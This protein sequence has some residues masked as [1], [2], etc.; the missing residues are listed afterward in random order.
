MQV[1]FDKT[2]EKEFEKIY[3]KFKSIELKADESYNKD[4][5]YL[6]KRLQVFE[7][8]PSICKKDNFNSVAIDGS[9]AE[10]IISLNDISVH[11]LTAAFAADRTHFEEGTTKHLNISPPVCT[12][13]E[14][15]TRLILL[16]EDKKDEVWQEFLDF[17]LYNYNEKL[18]DV[19]IRVIRDIVEIAFKQKKPNDPLPK[20]TT[21]ANI[22]MVATSIGLKLYKDNFNNFSSWM[23]S[24]RANAPSGWFEQFREVLEYAIAKA[25]L[26]SDTHFKY[27]FI[28]GSMNMLMDP[29]QKQPRLAP[30]YLLRDINLRALKN[31]TCIVAVSKTTTF[32]FIYRLALD[33][34]KSLGE[35]K[36]WFIRIPTETR[37][38]FILHILK[39]RPHI[40]PE[41]GVTYLFHFSSEVP[42]LRID[43]DEAWWNENIYS[44]DKK[45]ERENEIKLFK[46]IDWLAR[47][48]RYYGYFFDLAFAHNTTIV[49]FPERDDVA[50]RLIDY[51]TEK[52]EDPKMFIHPRKRLGLM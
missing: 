6:G 3:S 9:G 44:S 24:P 35:E 18:E 33:L 28:D 22:R 13:P 41:Y 42:I 48:V 10:G 32:P 29:G 50:E 19:V 36:K 23:V 17:I 31:E 52:G 14:G 11:L 40:P 26:D 1:F 34:E 49:R 30:N 5:S 4:L 21:E 12:H 16:R 7:P 38:N 8:C 20:L 43:L 2:L 39:D 45:K 47:D 15:I 51:F 37:D 25:L 46:D 27:I